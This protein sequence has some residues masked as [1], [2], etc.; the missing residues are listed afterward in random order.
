MKNET[1]RIVW[2]PNKLDE[3]IEE[4]RKKIGYTRSAFYRYAVTRLLEQMSIVSRNEI[5]L[6]PWEEISGTLSGLEADDFEISAILSC[7]HNKDIA[8]TFPKGSQEATVL[9][10]N[11]NS[12]LLGQKIA[13]LK[14]D[15]P[16]QPIII[17]PF[18]VT[19]EVV[20][21]RSQSKRPPG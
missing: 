7:T 14:T 17:K 1:R 2:I 13:I 9:K 18:A 5:R 11:L 4:N 15:S 10:Q 12:L 3:E 20:K 21:R 19:T 6:R 16:Q 8:I